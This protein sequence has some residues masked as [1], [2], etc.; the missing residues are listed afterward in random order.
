MKWVLISKLAELTGYSQGAIRS[1]IKKG[2][3]REPDH[4]RHAPDNRI[5]FNLEAFW[6]WVE[7]K[8]E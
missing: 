8:L 2:V 3:F 1:K 6:K 7:G 4:Y 5:L